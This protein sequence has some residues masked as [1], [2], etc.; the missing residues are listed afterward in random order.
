M[1][2]R[3]KTGQFCTYLIGL[4]QLVGNHLQ[5]AETMEAAEIVRPQQ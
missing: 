3:G 1:K 5:V 4:G 2:R